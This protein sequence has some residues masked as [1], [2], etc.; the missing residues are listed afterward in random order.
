MK[1]LSDITQSARFIISRTDNIGDVVLTLPVAALLK[2]YYQGCEVILLARDYVESIAKACPHV[3]QFL[4]WNKL[5]AMSSS[6]AVKTLRELDADTILHVFPHP[7]IAKLAKQAKIKTRIGTSHRLYHLL[8]CNKRV[9]FSRAKSNLHEAQL[10]LKLLAPLHVP[11]NFSL[12]QLIPLTR[13][14]TNERPTENVLNCLDRERFNLI[15]HPLSNGNGREWP[16]ENFV[17]LIRELPPNLFNVIVTG[18]S[19]EKQRLQKPLLDQCEHITDATGNLSLSELLLLLRHGDGL[20]VSS[21]GPLHIAAALGSRVLG[22][23]P[24]QKGLSIE[25][26]GPIGKQA[27]HIAIDKEC[28]ACPETGGCPCMQGITVNKVKSVI[29]KWL[30]AKLKLNK[31]YAEA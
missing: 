20:V 24:P 9:N 18:T 30:E 26:W 5:Q 12:Q 6:D 19:A 17:Q 31:F 14:H 15:I 13:L 25:R 8:T 27:Q 2:Q 22:L 10:N 3:D 4:S 7:A 28:F 23:F 21:T 29:G 11:V 1:P 16:I